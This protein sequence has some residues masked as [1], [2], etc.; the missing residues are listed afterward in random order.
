MKDDTLAKDTIEDQKDDQKKYELMVI[1]KP[2]IGEDGAKK[3]MEEV[4]KLISRQKG[5]IF[6]EDP[7]GLRDLAYPIKKQDRGFYTVLNFMLLPEMLKE[8][9]TTLRL[10]PEVLRHMIV[11]LPFKYEPKTLVTMEEEQKAKEEIIMKEKEA[12]Q[13]KRS[14]KSKVT[15][16]KKEEKEEVEVSKPTEESK[17]PS[18]EESAKKT[19]K[20]ET[21]LEDVDAKL[22]SIIDNPDINF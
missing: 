6:F 10:E 19:K 11:T 22:K 21:S 13:E 4:K 8:I 18:S 7:W 5:E 2:D 15:K 1:I 20:K 12:K 17:S 3:R 14:M 16:V 9:D